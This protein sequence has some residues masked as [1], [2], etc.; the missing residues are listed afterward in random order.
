MLKD[1]KMLKITISVFYTCILLI[2]I[3]DRHV[4][5][6]VSSVS[7]LQCSTYGLFSKKWSMNIE[8]RT[9]IFEKNHLTK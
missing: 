2:T 1:S 6:K 3:S 5:C 9:V 8:E 4:K 7:Q